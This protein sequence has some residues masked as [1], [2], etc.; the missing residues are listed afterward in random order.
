MATA[1]HV[2]A[3]N[4]LRKIR[5]TLTAEV[6][7]GRRLP[8]FAGHYQGESVVVEVYDVEE[9]IAIR[10]ALTEHGTVTFDS[11]AYRVDFATPEDHGISANLNESPIP[12]SAEEAK[13]LDLLGAMKR[14]G[15]VGKES[16]S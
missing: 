11:L 10:R 7:Q 1:T 9:A 15:I 16:E 5:V 13:A 6:R 3:S 2:P 14:L 4:G 8:W 12:L